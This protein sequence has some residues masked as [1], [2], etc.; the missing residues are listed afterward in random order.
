MHFT[1]KGGVNVDAYFGELGAQYYRY[2]KF[3]E[4]TLTAKERNWLDKISANAQDELFDSTRTRKRHLIKRADGVEEVDQIG[5]L[6]ELRRNLNDDGECAIVLWAFV[7]LMVMEI[8]GAALFP[9]LAW[10][11]GNRG[12]LIMMLMAMTGLVLGSLIAIGIALPIIR[13]Y[14]YCQRRRIALLIAKI[15]V[16][17]WTFDVKLIDAETF[18]NVEVGASADE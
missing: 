7:F 5:M 12:I 8:G 2:L 1:M 15:L 14:D 13:L 16:I 17:E 10:R 4:R 18:F 6:Y 3:G 11:A 9:I